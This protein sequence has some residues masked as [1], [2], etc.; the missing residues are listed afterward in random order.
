MPLRV[1]GN[2]IGIEENAVNGKRSQEK[3]KVKID[4][5]MTMKL[6]KPGTACEEAGVEY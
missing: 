2:E 4:R 1:E 6:E 5:K 3:E